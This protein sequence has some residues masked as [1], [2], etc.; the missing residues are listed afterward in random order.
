M[1][2]SECH[3]QEEERL[4]NPSL[5]GLGTSSQFTLLA[6]SVSFFFHLSECCSCFVLNRRVSPRTGFRYDGLAL[7]ISIRA[8]GTR[9]IAPA[10]IL[11]SFHSKHFI[12]SPQSLEGI[13]AYTNKCKRSLLK[14]DVALQ[15]A[16]SCFFFC[17]FLLNHLKGYF[18]FI[19]SCITSGSPLMNSL[20]LICSVLDFKSVPNHEQMGKYIV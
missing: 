2:R 4:T 15:G 11:S 8:E 6:L 7:A 12:T 3:V 1:C 20:S 10:L 18:C 14:V 9:G 5:S 16:L 13:F 19:S 17:F